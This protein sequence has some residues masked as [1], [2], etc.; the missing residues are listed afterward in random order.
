MRYLGYHHLGDA[1]PPPTIRALARLRLRRLGLK[2]PRFCGQGRLLDIGCWTGGYLERMTEVGWKVAG[3]ELHREAAAMAREVAGEI[4]VGELMS[5]PFPDESF[6]VVTAFHILEHLDDPLAA[7]RRIVS[8][9]APGG[10][11]IIEVPNFGGLGRRVFGSH[12]YGLDLPFHISHFTPET[13]TGAI[14]G[15]GGQ[16]IQIQHLS[17]PHYIT[18][19]L[20][21][22]TF[23]GQS[24]SAGMLEKFFG[25]SGGKRFLKVGLSLAC[26]NGL[27]EAIRVTFGPPRGRRIRGGS[28]DRAR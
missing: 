5:A 22:L 15:A 13:L 27:G 25:L 19:S 4:F 21:F 1:I 6:D 28:R 9:V 16:V 14:R 10:R 23:D 20:Q 2:F 18:R 11:A 17:D 3:I 7:L 24:A 8:W 26:R 12:W